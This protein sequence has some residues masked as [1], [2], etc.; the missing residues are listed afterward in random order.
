MLIVVAAALSGLLWLGGTGLHPIAALTWLAPLPLLLMS[1]RVRPGTALVATVAAWLI[2][3][4]SVVPYYYNT[5]RMPLPAVAGVVLLGAAL[6]T[7]TVLLAR[8]LLLAGRPVTAILTV[9]FL[10][11][12]GEYA[13]CRLLPHGAWWSLAY[14]QSTVRPIIQVT[15]LTGVWGVTY[16]LIAVPIAVAARTRPA[17]VCLLVLL[18]T[19]VGWSLTRPVGGREKVEVGL[20]A[21]EQ[22]DD[23]LPLDQSEG[24]ELLG[25]YRLRVD[26]LIARGAKIVVLPEK[27]FGVDS[28]NDLV[29]A[30]RPE[31]DRGVQVITGAVLKQGG[32]ARNVALVLGPHG[33]VT[34]Y[35]KQH[36]IPGLEDWLT[37]GHTD[38]IV[39]NQFG[40]AIC[41]D[42]DFPA[43]VRGYRDRGASVMLVPGLD[44]TGDGWLHSRMALVRGVESGLTVVRSAASGRLTVT[45][46]TGRV[47]AE[48]EAGNADLLVAAPLPEKRTIYSRTGDW[49]P[50]LAVAALIGVIPFRRVRRAFPA[51]SPRRPRPP[52]R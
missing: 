22:S 29:D 48:A 14:T 13:A 7:G 24:Q 49:F 31:T 12:L 35:T 32:T 42:L 47:T 20:V 52:G 19:S 51:G 6:A 26:S 28:E 34:A 39:G 21:L 25:R 1:V 38:L 40:V 3:Q 44:F 2:G 23:G 43:L 8:H 9:P 4:A 18:A 45:D 27:V 17:T 5:L 10:W 30:F 46:A 41:K 33:T 15:A 11:V 37:P 36:L 16:L 50:F